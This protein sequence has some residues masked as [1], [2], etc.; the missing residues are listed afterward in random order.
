[1]KQHNK[2]RIPK[3]YIL[4]NGFTVVHVPTNCKTLFRLEIVTRS[5]MFMEN[6]TETGFSHFLEHLLAFFPSNDYPDPFVNQ[7]EVTRRGLNVNA[8]TEDNTV[9]YFVEGLRKYLELMIHIVMLS[10][11]EPLIPEEAYKNEKQ[12]VLRE[13]DGYINDPWYNLDSM[14]MAI[15]YKG[16]NLQHSVKYEKETVEKKCTLEKLIEFRKRLYCPQRTTLIISC[17]DAINDDLI[18][19]IEKVYF[20][21]LLQ[22]KPEYFAPI[23]KQGN[24][25]SGSS[26]YFFAKCTEN[27]NTYKFEVFFPIPFQQ[28]DDRV[29]VLNFIHS[30]LT[31]GMGSR[32]YRTLRT[33]V[34]GVYYVLSENQF[35][36]LVPG[37]NYFVITS[38]TTREKFID[39]HDHLM[40]EFA[41]LCEDFHFDKEEIEQYCNNIQSLR[42]IFVCS[43]SAFE[44]SEFHKHCI[45]WGRPFQSPE[46][47]LKKRREILSNIDFIHQ[48]IRQVFDPEKMRFFYSGNE[49]LL[50]SIANHEMRNEYKEISK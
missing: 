29:Y 49:P 7:Q 44:E 11:I 40:V 45:V 38:E 39:V 42:D 31:N 19:I 3:R 25:Y 24:P 6:K 30:V 4:Q 13:L 27:E 20:P 14:V 26:K 46:E 22:H 17:N 21:N 48:V 41:A 36:P 10:F 5:G 32:L 35:T 23:S 50:Q 47:I 18:K 15:Q 16:T 1:M 37:Y 43:N 12:S 8:Y 33:H 9:G 34:G 28:F 2:K